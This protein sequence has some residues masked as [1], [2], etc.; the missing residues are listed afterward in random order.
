MCAHP[1][2]HRHARGRARLPRF[3]RRGDAIVVQRVPGLDRTERADLRADAGVRLEAMLPLRD[4]EVVVAKDGDVEGAIAALEADADVVYAEPD[5]TVFPATG[6]PSLANQWGLH[7]T[8][9]TIFGTPGTADADI[10]APEAW[11]MTRG[12][13]ATVA[14]VDTGVELT[15][16]DLVGQFTGNPGER[17][18]GRETNGVDDDGNGRVDDWR[19]WDFVNN[20]NSRRDPGQLPRHA[21]RGHDRGAARTTRS[22]SPASRRTRRCVPVKIF[23]G[24]GSTAPSSAIA[25]A[26]DYAGSLGVD[27]VNASLGGMGT[28]QVV[29]DAMNAHPNTLYVVVGGQRRRQRRELLPVQLAGG[30]PR[31]RR[32]EH[33][34][35][36]RPDFSNTSATVVDLFAPGEDVCRPSWR[37]VLLR[38]RHVDG[39][40]ARRRRRGAARRDA[41]GRDGRPD[42]RGAAGVGR[43]EGA[44]RAAVGHRRAAER[45][46]GARRAAGFLDAAAGGNARPGAADADTD[47]ACPCA[48]AAGPHTRG[49]GRAVAAGPGDRD[50]AA[51]GQGRLRAQRRH[52]RRRGH[53]LHRRAY[54][55]AP[56]A[57]VRHRAGVRP[58]PSPGRQA[59]R[60]RQVHADAVDAGR[61]G[62]AHQLR[63][64]VDTS[65][66][67]DLTIAALLAVPATGAYFADDQAAIKA[68]A[69]R[70]GLAY[71]GAPLTPGFDAIRAPAEAV[72]VLL[73]L[74]DGH[75]AHGDCVSVQYAGVGGRE[76]R[77]R[78]P[79]L[80]ARSSA[81]SHR[82]SPAGR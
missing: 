78:A 6:D 27:V 63:R 41:P 71:P 30:E 23:G 16:P 3:R 17:G 24:P 22:A 47:A 52:P 36:Q 38:E 61:R 25:T 40:A 68:G 51:P 75:V 42:A 21:R 5:A 1:R 72:S 74:S 64:A 14:V 7:N 67:P 45:G 19:G 62:A 56:A 65:G 54:V 4:T 8:G 31:V 80:A 82:G 50:V 29:T 53:P 58:E 81:R 32:V 79:D 28:S 9:Q 55:H 70:D 66:M 48:D 44:V 46:R 15:H 33:N 69:L 37:R 18:G 77:L 43:R 57:A 34:R 39:R 49:G 35:D 10:D 59:A 76:P 11:A 13:G 73:V 2:R 20:D 60:N 12:A 26:F